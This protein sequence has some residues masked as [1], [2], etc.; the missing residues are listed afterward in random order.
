MGAPRCRVFSIACVVL[1]AATAHAQQSRAPQPRTPRQVILEVDG[2]FVTTA[3]SFTDTATPLIHAEPGQFTAAYEV[4]RAAA[5]SVGGHV[6]VWRHV[7]AGV[8]YARSSRS[9]SA[10]ITGAVP[11]PFFFSRNRTIEGEASNATRS[12]ATLAVQLRGSLR[13]ARQTMLSVFGGPAWISVTQGLVHQINFAESYPYDTASFTSATVRS[14]KRSKAA[15]LAG[16]DLSHFF[17][18]RIG[19]GGGFRYSAATVNLPSLDSDVLTTKAGGL[20]VTAGIRLR[21]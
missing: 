5:F 17:S 9:S 20:D 19:V 14:A 18:R 10:H 12:D 21:F 7:R 1:T 13:V 4:P 8:S 11:H 6:R 2:S 16:A 3:R 15:F